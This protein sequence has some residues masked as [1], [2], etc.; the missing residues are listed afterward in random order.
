MNYD[1]RSGGSGQAKIREMK[2][3]MS[4]LIA[5]FAFS[6]I[7]LAQEV[8]STQHSKKCVPTKECAEKMGMT[9]EQCIALCK[10]MEADKKACGTSETN[11][12][13]LSVS[14][15]KNQDQST[16]KPSCDIKA[17]A[18]KAGVSVEEYIRRC[19]PGATSKETTRKPSEVTVR[20]SSY[21]SAKNNTVEPKVR[22]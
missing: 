11:S 13:V 18:R 9:L 3:L 6:V 8:Q 10:K 15:E 21:N 14:M 19:C 2:K 22:S 7:T 17:C 16:G 20:T 1:R 12:A 5:F 4:L